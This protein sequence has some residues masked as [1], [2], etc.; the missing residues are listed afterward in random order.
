MVSK[1]L[2]HVMFLLME[3]SLAKLGFYP[4][5]IVEYGINTLG[6][7]QMS[8]KFLKILQALTKKASTLDV[9]EWH[10]VFYIQLNKSDTI[11]M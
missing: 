6:G 2:L 7:S 8:T 1:L 3:F 5:A 9:K 11:P 10:S 4:N